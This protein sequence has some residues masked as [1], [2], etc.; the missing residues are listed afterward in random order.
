MRLSFTVQP[1]G[2]SGFDLQMDE[3]DHPQLVDLGFRQFNYMVKTFGE[4]NSD[5]NAA[6]GIGLPSL[7]ASS[8]PDPDPDAVRTGHDARPAMDAG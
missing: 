6:A 5:G 4:V 1:D 2:T 7:G 8:I 3:R